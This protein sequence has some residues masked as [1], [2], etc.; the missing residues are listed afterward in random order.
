MDDTF[1]YRAA[2]MPIHRRINA[3]GIK[4]T[5]LFTVALC[6]VVAFSRW[7]VDSERRSEAAA[8]TGG[9]D[10][11]VVGMLP[12]IDAVDAEA[13]SSLPVLD[14][15]ARADARTALGTAREAMRGR[16]TAAE[17]GPGQLSTIERSLVF[18]DGPS[19][20]PGIVSV[21]TVGGRWAGAVMGASGTCYWVSAGPSGVT[22]GSGESCTGTAA[23]TATETGW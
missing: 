4:L 15:P 20:A 17:A 10:Q 21:A 2:P 7:V 5:V 1:S 16:A 6:S 8:A 23:L 18:T 3:R 13:A 14:A 22:Y 11:P 9:I 19:P 12:G